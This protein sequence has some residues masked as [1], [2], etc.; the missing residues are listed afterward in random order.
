MLDE[1]V[2]DVSICMFV[3]RQYSA[4]PRGTNK[5]A[6]EA[7]DAESAV[8]AAVWNSK[9]HHRRIVLSCAY[10]GVFVDHEVKVHI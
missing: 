10:R 1:D 7:S 3:F 8:C 4:S 5:C 6:S 2:C 9:Q